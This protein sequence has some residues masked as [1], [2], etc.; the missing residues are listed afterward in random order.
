[1][2]RMLFKSL[3][4]SDA[5]EKNLVDAALIFQKEGDVK[6][7]VRSGMAPHKNRLLG[8][9]RAAVSNLKETENNDP[10]ARTYGGGKQFRH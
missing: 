1:M 8:A 7:A 10:S 4:M 9:I 6:D 3:N 2:L 5:S